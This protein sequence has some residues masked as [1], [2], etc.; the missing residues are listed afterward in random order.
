MI[1][2]TTLRFILTD[3]DNVSNMRRIIIVY[4]FEK[5]LEKNMK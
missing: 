5:L 2:L 3:G 4:N 1:I